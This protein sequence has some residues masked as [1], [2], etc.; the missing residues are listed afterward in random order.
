M[1]MNSIRVVIFDCDGVLFDTVQANKSY[2]NRVLARFNKPEM[3]GEQFAY[4]HMHTADESI[5]HLFPDEKEF[6]AA[7]KYRKEMGYDPFIPEMIIEPGLMS[8]IKR[9]K[10]EYKTAVATN[11]SDTMPRV[12]EAFEL[13]DAF[14]LIVTARDVKRP[15][16]HPEQ[17][18][19][20]MEHFGVGPH[21]A[22][23]LGDSSVDEAAAKGANICFVA[24]DNRDLQA[25]FHITRLEQMVEI[26]G[27]SSVD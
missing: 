11:R 15:K 26:L 5:A 19:R 14:D 18:F 23:Y 25:D 27:L 3:T 21:E 1:N 16:P 17:L 13:S 4:V 6:E 10:P 12:V 22:I 2:Y 9:L 7:Q 24:Y 20:V 8:L